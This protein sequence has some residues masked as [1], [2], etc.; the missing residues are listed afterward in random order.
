MNTVNAE[1]PIPCQAMQECMKGVT[2]RPWSPERIVKAHERAA[3]KCGDEIVCS[4]AKRKRQK[5]GIKNLHGN[6]WLEDKIWD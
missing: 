1:M 4:A 6:K 3:P 5:C 2:T